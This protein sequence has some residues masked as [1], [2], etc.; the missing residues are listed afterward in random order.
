M[1]D[2]DVGDIMSVYKSTELDDAPDI[3]TRI[4]SMLSRLEA[5]ENEIAALDMDVEDQI[6][7]LA[8]DIGMI[9]AIVDEHTHILW[10][11]MDNSLD[12]WRST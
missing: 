7:E 4:Q 5:V 1:P 3:N 6:A 11:K 9:G 2:V 10:D 12:K 8:A